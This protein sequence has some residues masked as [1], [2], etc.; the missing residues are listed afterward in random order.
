[1]VFIKRKKHRRLLGG[2]SHGWGSHKKHRGAGHHGGAGNSG[3]AG[4]KKPS[5][6]HN[7]KY[8]GK[9]GF[10]STNQREN[11][12]SKTINIFML[13]KKIEKYVQEGKAKKENDFFIINLNDI[14]ADKL[15]GIGYTKKK[16]KIT[17][18]EASK[19]SLEKIQSAGGEVNILKKKKDKNKIKTEKKEKT[20]MEQGDAKEELKKNNTDYR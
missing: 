18:N 12:V 7:N 14:K 9:H 13:D 4:A 19:T 6:W 3:S 20:E 17:C 15:L 8:F 1:M 5:Y 16:F 11:K 10:I 2:R